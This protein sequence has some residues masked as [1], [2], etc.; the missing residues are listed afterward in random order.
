MCGNCH[1]PLDAAPAQQ[2]NGQT[3]Y[4]PAVAGPGSVSAYRP[5]VAGP[6]SVMNTPASGSGDEHL[7]T[8]VGQP[9]GG[10]NKSQ[11]L[12]G[13]QT[14]PYGTVKAPP[15]IKYQEKPDIKPVKSHLWANILGSIITLA[16]ILG[17][18]G[19]LYNKYILLPKGPKDAMENFVQAVTKNDIKALQ[20]CTN[21][22][23]QATINLALKAQQQGRGNVSFD[24]FHSQGQGFEQGKE[25]R[26]KIES[27]DE[28]SAK[29]L[30]S[31]GPA[32]IDGFKD[33]DLPPSHKEGYRFNLVKEGEKWKVDLNKFLID[34]YSM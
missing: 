14:D 34:M 24:I 22:V 32:P 2:Q 28:K 17:V 23:S 29:V 7:Q 19:F 9:L 21:E 16:V 27:M 5:D 31:P 12:G 18:G 26:I 15:K 20:D 13:P 30:V 25:Y 3:P 11:S 1:A 6:G 10:F 8:V 33:S 4:R